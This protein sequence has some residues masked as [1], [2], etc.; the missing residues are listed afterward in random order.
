MPKARV[1]WQVFLL[2]LFFPLCPCIEVT[3]IESGSQ[4]CSMQDA[5][6][7]LSLFGWMKTIFWSHNLYLFEPA[8][9]SLV[10]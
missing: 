3:H 10:S 7:F 1:E 5:W 6:N 2:T 9:V 8:D 4:H